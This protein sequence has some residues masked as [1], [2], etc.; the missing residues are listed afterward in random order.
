M[1]DESLTGPVDVCEG[2]TVLEGSIKE[3]EVIRALL[4]RG[5]SVDLILHW[6]TPLSELLDF[7]RGG[8]MQVRV[9]TSRYV[10]GSAVCANVM[11][12]LGCDECGAYVLSP[13]GRS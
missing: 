1:V 6:P 13:V 11:V 8:E 7:S 10:D 4:H 5:M 9:C 12:G 3:E 2:G